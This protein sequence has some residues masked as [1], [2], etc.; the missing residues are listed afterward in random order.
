MLCDTPKAMT[1]LLDIFIWCN[2]LFIFMFP[3]M[4]HGFLI[5]SLKS[6]DCILFKNSLSFMFDDLDMVNLTLRHICLH[7]ITLKTKNGNR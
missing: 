1:Y 2:I 4:F 5:I 6:I 7:C 3:F